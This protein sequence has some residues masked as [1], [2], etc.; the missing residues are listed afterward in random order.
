MRRLPILALALILSAL[1][2]A[3]AAPVGCY[4]STGDSDWLWTSP[5]VNSPAS[6]EA[7]FDVLQKVY[8][9]DRMYWRAAACELVVDDYDS[10]PANFRGHGFWEWERHLIKGVGQAGLGVAAAHRRGMTIWGW[11]SMFD[12]GAQAHVDSAKVGMPAP[13]EDRL[14]IAHPEYVP[15][16]RAGIRRQAGPMEFAYPQ[17]RREWVK[18]YVDLVKR[19]GYDGLCF[20][21]YVEH[22]SIR[23]EDE[24]GY[25]APIVAE[26]KRRYGQDITRERFDKHAWYRLRGEYVTQFL[27]ELRAALKPLGTKLGVAID[28]QESHYPAPWLCQRDTINTGRIYL[29]WE[30]WVREGLVDEIMV[31]CNGS[32]EA[33]LNDAVAVTQGTRCKVSALHSAPFPARH[34]HFDDAGVRRVMVGS[35]DWIEWGYK[36][37]QPASAID[38]GDF[39]KRLRVLRQVVEKKTTL[40]LDRIVKA[41]R[42][43]NVLVR[44]QA[45]RTLEALDAKDAI[46]AIEA[47]LGDSET[48]VRCTAVAALSKLNRDGTVARIFAA[49]RAR[50]EFQFQEAA[51]SSLANMPAERTA[52]IAA[53]CTDK[54]AT[55]RR[56]A[57]WV[58][59]RGRRRDD[60][61]PHLI[62]A[63][64]DPVA[65]VRYSAANG[66]ARYFFKPGVKARLLAHFDDPHPSVRSRIALAFK[67]CFQS[68]SRW[69][70]ADQL[71]ATRALA[72]A[73]AKCPQSS[74]SWTFRPIGYAL[75]SMGPRGEEA[76]RGFMDQRRDKT[77][78][79][80]AWRILYVPQTGW[81]YQLC[82]EA[83]ARQGYLKHP[84]LSGWKPVQ[85]PARA[86]EPARMPYLAQ[87]FDAIAPYSKGKVGDLL[88]HGGQ[89]RTLGDAHPLPVVED[90]IKHGD[91][92]HAL[93]LRRGK[94]GS[95]H[96]IEILRADY[97]LTTQHAIIEWWF[98]NAH[99]RS[100]FA[101]TWKDS[102][103]GHWYIGV[104]IPPDGRVGYVTDDRKWTY[105]TVRLPHGKWQRVR[106]D[107]DGAKCRYSIFA[108][109]EKLTLVRKD[110]PFPAGQ[111]YNILTISA[112][113]AEGTD[114]YIDDVLVSVPNPAAGP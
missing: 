69:V 45:I 30:R 113:G 99:A 26:F 114:T 2:L 53:G 38:S 17:V 65:Y 50:P 47:A 5:P 58:L 9:V 102:G 78:A 112:Q 107:V 103:S 89:L 92:G 86:P 34:R 87:N 108:G 82:T 46:P 72:A 1:P 66:L 101:A 31:Y 74:D 15:I 35:Y 93:R 51:S 64:D 73:F 63:M 19:R 56:V 105:S 110:I 88:H 96:A 109:G 111:T 55:V 80:M 24:F 27:R 94:P 20:Y 11:C 16:D 90:Q 85:K 57:T 6:I 100:A 22:N 77:L 23:F 60:A 10:R 39:L 3:L 25:N 33:A 8:G 71:R 37:E 42:D 36:E 7:L 41:T 75:A 4:V 95:P 61:V 49:L 44:R 79:D 21:T 54:N 98:M 32:L 106:L 104:S 59:G 67:S 81:R 91:Q 48:G 83:E 84:V 97:R 14:R 13:I 70:G 29:D 28:P 18:R 40:P 12:S 43:P 68:H 62:K 76:L 52:E